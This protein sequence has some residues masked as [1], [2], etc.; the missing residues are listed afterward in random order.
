MCVCECTYS[1]APPP[2]VL[3]GFAAAVAQEEYDKE[4]LDLWSFNLT[5]AEMDQLSAV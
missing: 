1:C 2:L 5:Q 3:G 4:D